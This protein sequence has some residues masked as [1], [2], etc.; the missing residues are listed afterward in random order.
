MNRSVSGE[1]F[2]D[3]DPVPHG[4]SQCCPAAVESREQLEEEEGRE[5]NQEDSSNGFDTLL[6]RRS[7]AFRARARARSHIGDSFQRHSWGPGT[8][9]QDPISR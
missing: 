5:E 1:S 9:F 3:E 7:G 6:L 8:E 4:L 2:I